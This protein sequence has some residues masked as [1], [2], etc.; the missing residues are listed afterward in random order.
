MLQEQEYIG[1]LIGAARRRIRQAVTAQAA[2]YGLKAQEFWVLNAARE[3]PGA[4]LGALAERQ[5][6]ELPTASRVVAALGKRG[7]LKIGPDEH[8]RR[9]ALI[10][11]T[12]KGRKLA[13]ELSRIGRSVRAAVIEGMSGPEQDALRASL[14]KILKNLDR[15]LEEGPRAAG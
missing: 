12:P 9:R 8:D 6:M 11:L 3:L 2:R 1:V 13:G 4:S 15:Y 7:L 10:T 5:H 14:R